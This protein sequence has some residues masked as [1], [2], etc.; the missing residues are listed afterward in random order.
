MAKAKPK[1]VETSLGLISGRGLFIPPFCL[2]HAPV[3]G[4]K[5]TGERQKNLPLMLNVMFDFEFL[6]IR[7][8]Q[9]DYTCPLKS[10]YFFTEKYVRF[11]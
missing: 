2:F 7:F 4:G 3:S 9:N 10:T 11:Y 5:S 6:I 1:Y 8:R